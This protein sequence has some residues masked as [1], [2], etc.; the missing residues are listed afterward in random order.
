MIR[1]R[2]RERSAGA[3][4]VA[5]WALLRVLNYAFSRAGG[6]LLNRGRAPKLCGILSFFSRGELFFRKR[7]VVPARAADLRLARG[8]RE[9]I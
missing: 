2:L 7:K 3:E 5:R 8:T 1:V 9:K 6:F 4:I